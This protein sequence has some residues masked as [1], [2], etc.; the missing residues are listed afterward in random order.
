MF[1]KWGIEAS[2]IAILM[3][4]N[5]AILL[6]GSKKLDDVCHEGLGA[7]V[8][9]VVN[10]AGGQGIKL[11][12]ALPEPGDRFRSTVLKRAGFRYLSNLHYLRRDSARGTTL[13]ARSDLEWTEYSDRCR[14]A[15]LQTLERT[16]SQ[17]LDFPELNGIRSSEEALQGYAAVGRHEPGLWWLASV[18]KEPAGILLQS[19]I[20]ECGTIELVYCGVTQPF[21]RTGVA[22]ALVR[23]A[24]HQTGQIG[25]RTM[26]LGVDER[27]AP[28]H[29]LYRRWGFVPFA[30][31]A[32][33]IATPHKIETSE[34]SGY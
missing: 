32:A 30:I 14:E 28:A 20:D 29:R 10:E 18:A 21:R 26:A 5:Q 12:E 27:N 24:V 7:A 9:A 33:W 8:A 2:A 16:L 11:L 31:R 17:S 34:F 19:E 4:G 13:S 25:A 22:D 15:F 6:I 23:R 3:P 1:S